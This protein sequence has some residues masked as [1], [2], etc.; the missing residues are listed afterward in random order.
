VA[1]DFN[2]APWSFVLRQLQQAADVQD[3]RRGFGGLTTWA[4]PPLVHLSLDHVFAS[5]ELAVQ[6][7]QHGQHGGSDHLSIIVDFAIVP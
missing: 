1:G 5:D 6:N 7:Y 2:A 3:T 4:G